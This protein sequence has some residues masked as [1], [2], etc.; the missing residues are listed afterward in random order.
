MSIA[1]DGATIYFHAIEYFAL[2]AHINVNHIIVNAR[3]YITNFE[4]NI[5]GTGYIQQIHDLHKIIPKEQIN[6]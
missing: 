5:T 6:S 4:N 1:S 2:R 3:S